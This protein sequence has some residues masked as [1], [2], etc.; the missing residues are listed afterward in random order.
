LSSFSKYAN[1]L[2]IF[3]V[4][5]SP[6]QTRVSLN[7]IAVYL[8]EAEVSEQVSSLKMDRSGPASAEEDDRLGLENASFKW[9]EVEEAPDAKDD[10]DK[11][12]K[13]TAS[14]TDSILTAA[15]DAGSVADHK[16]ELK[17]LSV[18]FP[19]GELTVVTGPT[20][21]C[22]SLLVLWPV[23]LLGL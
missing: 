23:C 22:A 21:R 15:S 5:T 9:N 19:E 11:N 16:F 6:R 4:L 13:N 1:N 7:R 17:D 14:E 10:K 2:S 12:G 18:V 8:E 20:A 3:L